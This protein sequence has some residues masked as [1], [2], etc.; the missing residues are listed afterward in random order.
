MTTRERTTMSTLTTC[1][2]IQCN[3]RWDV[4]NGRDGGARTIRAMTH[5][6]RSGYNRGCRCRP[7]TEANSAAS[8]TRRERIAERSTTSIPATRPRQ[9]VEAITDSAASAADDEVYPSQPDFPAPLEPKPYELYPRANSEDRPR[10]RPVPLAERL[11]SMSKAPAQKP[12]SPG[13]FSSG[14][15]TTRRFAPMTTA[16]DQSPVAR[17]KPPL[18]GTT[19]TTSTSAQAQVSREAAIASWDDYARRLSFY[20]AGKGENPDLQDARRLYGPR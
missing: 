3:T 11:A 6:T 20:L 4:R 13:L 19:S 7:C 18:F 9:R 5:G 2:F 16:P 12:S 10:Y 1:D 17:R 8:R 15:F 14:L